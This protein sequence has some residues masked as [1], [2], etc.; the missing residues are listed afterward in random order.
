MGRSFVRVSLSRML[1]DW[2]RIDDEFDER[3]GGWRPPNPGL[4]WRRRCALAI[5][6][7]SK[8]ECETRA[9]ALARRLIV[10]RLRGEVNRPN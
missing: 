9:D 7:I 2:N 6:V 8:L 1:A 10:E 4:V 5:A 3:F